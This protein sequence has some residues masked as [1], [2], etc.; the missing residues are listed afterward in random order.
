[1]IRNEVA[2]RRT[3]EIEIPP[4]LHEVVLGHRPG[5]N[6]RMYLGRGALHLKEPIALEADT[7][8]GGNGPWVLGMDD[9]S[10]ARNDAGLLLIESPGLRLEPHTTL[11]AGV[12]FD[13]A[14]ALEVLLEF[15]LGLPL[16]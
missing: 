9:E 11:H 14:Q 5:H 4:D 6:G 7:V 13:L 16:I 8:Y 1:M 10:G 15:Q 12:P 3:R 2:D